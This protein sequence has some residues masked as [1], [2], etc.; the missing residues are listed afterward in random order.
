M[1]PT[2]S[3]DVARELLGRLKHPNEQI[4]R[5]F[6]GDRPGRQPVHTVYGGAHLFKSDTAQKMGV[7]ALAALHEYAPD[8]AAL[9]RLLRNALALRVFTAIAL[10]LLVPEAL[11]AP[12]QL[13]YHTG[14]GL[15]ARYWSNETFF[16]PG[17]PPA[18]P[19]ATTCRSRLRPASRTRSGSAGQCSTTR[20]SRTASRTGR[21]VARSSAPPTP[22]SPSRT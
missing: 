22:A 6:P 16:P 17:S 13:A 18:T 2:L 19:S 3:D 5:L 14:G 9:R 7:V 15:L 4:Q 21:T 10:H 8:A 1:K 12:D 20:S 11:F